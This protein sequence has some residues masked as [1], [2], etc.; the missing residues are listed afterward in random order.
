MSIT[1][2]KF[3]EFADGGD[4]ENSNITVGLEG[5][6]NT[7]F[8]NPWTFLASGTTGDRPAPAADMYY[9]LRFNTTLESYEYYDPVSADWVQLEDSGDISDLIARLAA[10]TVG[11]GAS[12]IGLQDQTGVSNKT[13]QDLANATLIA[14]TDNGT[15][16]NGQFMDDLANGVMYN[17][18]G[19]LGADANFT[20]NGSG[21]VSITG[22]LSVDNLRLDGNTLSSTDTNGNIALIPNGTGIVSVNNTAAYATEQRGI[23]QAFNNVTNGAIAAATFGTSE[24]GD[25]NAYRTRSTT[26]GVFSAV[27]AADSVGRFQTWADDGTGFV[28]CGRIFWEATAPISAGIVP[29]TFYIQAMD[30]L[31]NI[32]TVIEG[33]ESGIALNQPLDVAYGGTGLNTIGANQLLYGVSVGNFAGLPTAANAILTTDGS[34]VPSWTS[35]T[36]PVTWSGVAGTS[37][38]AAVNHGYIIQNAATTTVTLPATAAIGSIVAVAGL[39]AGGWVLTANTGQTIKISP[40]TTSSAGSLASTAQYDSVEVVCVTANTTWIVRSVQSS[41]LTVT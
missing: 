24:G 15:L 14:Q 40:A 21:T 9:R 32:E 16:T 19:V 22:Q 31:G 28:R 20:T 33:D 13:V 4:L 39:G 34:G 17:T 30:S 35:G 11:D 27:Q 8:N 23:I 41:G 10:H 25:F 5:G 1:T 37:Q 38:A 7:R 2:R 3:S 36:F 18:G 26:I 29:T 6:A 12:M